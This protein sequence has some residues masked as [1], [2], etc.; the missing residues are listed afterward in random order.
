MTTTQ[1]PPPRLVPGSSE[2]RRTI[3]ASKVPVILGLSRFQSQYALWHEMA[4]LVE[5]A[6]VSDAQQD[7][8]DYG[9][10]IET[11]AAEYWRY[12][13]P[14][15]RLSSGEVAFHDPTLPFPNQATVD[16]RG[17]RGRRRRIVEVKSA[18][19][20]ED[21]GD[22]GTGELPEDY[23]AQILMQQRISGITADADLVLWPAFGYPRIYT[24]TYDAEVAEY[25][26][27]RCAKWWE[28]L[29][30]G[31]APE[32]DDS[33]T[34]YEVVRRMHEGIDRDR[35][36]EIDITE[37]LRLL[38]AVQEEKD[39]TAAARGAKSRALDAAGTAQYLVCN[40]IRIADRRPNS[41]GTV[42]LYPKAKSLP[43]V[44]ALA[45]LRSVA[46]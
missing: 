2:W 29:E 44:R 42:S 37:A 19:S 26:V 13:N 9:H 6:P 14:G 39:A 1:H 15:W 27:G 22:D 10:A 5:P 17:S 21:W 32:L 4:G 7:V 11:A 18:R 8:F 16:R 46:S 38:E 3:T 24:V 45:R 36:V 25:I 43:E 35:E 23:A 28:S 41:A 20:L 33:V 31:T 40:G 34:T 12:R 30:S